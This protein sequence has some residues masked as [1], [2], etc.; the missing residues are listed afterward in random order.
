MDA[1]AEK[2]ALFRYGL[3]APLILETYLVESS[4][5]E[6]RKLPRVPMTFRFPTPLPLRRHLAR[7][8]AALSPRWFC[9]LGAANPTGPGAVARPHPTAGRADRTTETREPT[10]YRHHAAARTGSGLH[11]RH[12]F[13]FHLY[14]FLKQRG[15]TARQL[16]APAPRKKFEA[17]FRDCMLSSIAC[18]RRLPRVASPFAFMWTRQSSFAVPSWRA[19]PPPSA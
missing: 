9:R 7:L 11:R 15:L 4:Q 6:Q 8:G 16:L 3:I 5:D 1:K 2:I 10:P 12:G 14:R 13:P 18:D 19:L 17:E